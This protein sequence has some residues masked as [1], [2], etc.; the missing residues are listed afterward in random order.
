MFV[1]SL[2]LR[3]L[4]G[5]EALASIHGCPPK[6]CLATEDLTE[7]PEKFFAAHRLLSEYATKAPGYRA[8]LESKGLELRSAHIKGGHGVLYTNYSM[9]LQEF[10]RSCVG[11]MCS[12]L[13]RNIDR[14]SFP[15]RALVLRSLSCDTN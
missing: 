8:V 4:L 10:L 2:R 11:S 6:P 7:A 9:G 13:T 3:D 5:P 14:S 1:G 15:L 12:W